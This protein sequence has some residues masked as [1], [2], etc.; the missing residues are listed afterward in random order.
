MFAIPVHDY[1]VDYDT[2]NLGAI[3]RPQFRRGLLEA[4]GKSYCNESPTMECWTGPHIMYS[5]MAFFFLATYG[6]G[7]P[8]FCIFQISNIFKSKR[9]FD[10]DMRDR[11]GY[12]YYKYKTTH[13]YWEPIVIM[14]RKVFI[15][16]FRI[17]TRPKEYHLLQASGIMIFLRITHHRHYGMGMTKSKSQNSDF[18]T[19]KMKYQFFSYDDK[20]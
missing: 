3:T 17:L 10:P 13:F 20:T 4:F 18:S 15:A 5:N 7:F 1:L 16:L 2:H 11:Y 6:V 8:L 19:P 9:E 12:L 14:P